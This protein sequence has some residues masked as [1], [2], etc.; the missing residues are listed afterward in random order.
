MERLEAHDIRV[1]IRGGGLR[2]IRVSDD[3]HG[4]PADQVEM[5]LRHHATSKIRKVR[6]LLEIDSLGFRGEAL[7]SIAAVSRM[8][9]LTATQDATAVLLDCKYGN[10]VDRRFASRPRGTTV[11]PCRGW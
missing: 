7:P 5:A 4:L 9:L 2:S 6:D 11:E 8:T 10:V 3:G 1:D